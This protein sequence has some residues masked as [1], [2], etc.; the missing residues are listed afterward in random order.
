[1]FET[2]G[3]S[4]SMLAPALSRLVD[5]YPTNDI[6]LK[7]HPRGYEMKV[8]RNRKIRSKPKLNIQIVSKGKDKLRVKARYNA[9]VDTL[10]VEINQL[11]GKMNFTNANR[12]TPE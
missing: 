3:V 4:E 2:I 10:K 1:M 12:T 11:G 5:S 6:Y 9:I 7:T 8:S